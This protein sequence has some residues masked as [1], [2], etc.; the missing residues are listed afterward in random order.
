MFLQRLLIEIGRNKTLYYVAGIVRLVIPVRFSAH[1]LCQILKSCEKIDIRRVEER[2]NYYNKLE[3]PV[4]IGENAVELGK[5][6]MFK[7]PKSY[8]FDTHQY[9]RFYDK[10]LRINPLFGDVT[11]VDTV[12]SIQK[13]RPVEGDNSNAI[14]L[15]LDK[16]RHFLFVKDSKKFVD[17]KNMLIGRGVFSQPHRIKFI[18][19]YYNSP[20][21]DLGDVRK[22]EIAGAWSKPRMHILDHLDYKFILSLEGNDVATNLKWIMSSN[23]VAVMPKP[24]YETWFMEGKL[25]PNHHYIAIKEDFSDLEEQV[26]YY[27]HNVEEAQ[28][29][30]RNANNYVSQFFNK[31][32]ED[33]ISLLVLQKYFRFTSQELS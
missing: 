2:L 15:N 10:R 3:I 31:K 7:S 6:K 18:E 9:A 12:P 33:L 24:R 5:I 25:I 14:L 13:S 32:Q 22:P 21:C 30:V 16:K 11:F 29:I 1:R 26:T 4:A 17:K 20:L 27:I 8:N 19:K 28:A 23:S